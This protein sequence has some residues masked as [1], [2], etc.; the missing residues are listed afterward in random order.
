MLNQYAES[1]L[2][3]RKSRICGKR[4]RRRFCGF[5]CKLR[6]M[7]VSIFFVLSRSRDA[8]CSDFRVLYNIVMLRAR[9]SGPRADGYLADNS[10]CADYQHQTIQLAAGCQLARIL[11]FLLRMTIFSGVKKS[12]LFAIQVLRLNEPIFYKLRNKNR[13]SASRT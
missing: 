7:G 5:R 1:S 2:R 12:S 4:E 3:Q 9:L 8:I 6:E 10:D 13:Q 11:F